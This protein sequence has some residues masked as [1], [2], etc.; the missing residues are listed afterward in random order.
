[1]KT[2][3]LALLITPSF[4]TFSQQTYVPDDNFEAF[5]EGSGLGN[6][7]PN[8]DSVTTSNVSG[9]AD[10][11][12]GSLGIAVIT[13]IEDFTSVTLVIFDGNPITSADFS[14]NDSLEYV[15]MSNCALTSINVSQNVLL[16]TLLCS[17]NSLAS[18]DVSA[19]PL[20]E[21]LNCDGNSLNALDVTQ[22]PELVQLSLNINQVGSIDVTQNT[23]LTELNCV[24]AGLTLLD[25]T[26]NT[27]LISLDCRSNSLTDLDVSQNVALE[28]FFCRANS[29]TSLDVS[30]NPN[31]NNFNCSVNDLY[32]LNADNSNDF[33]N[34][35]APGTYL[36]VSFGNSN[37]TC[38]E[39]SFPTVANSSYIADVGTTFNADC[40]PPMP[41]SSV[42][43]SGTLLTAD[44][45]SAMYQW[46][47][48]DNNNDPIPGA[49]SQ[50]FTPTTTGSYAVEITIA[51]AC[52]ITNTNTSDCFLVDYTGIEELLNTEKELVKIIDLTGRETAFTTNTPLIFMYSD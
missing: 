4:C 11:I 35:L 26:Q 1:M 33:E 45:G 39:V 14:Q 40:L 52:G 43:Q 19:C 15:G 51:N 10:L 38:A 44:L 9:L 3:L 6:G 34:P 27:L 13:G 42:T 46:V 12:V 18:I 17:N 20:L 50:S 22:N 21:V 36:F 30:A 16:K 8:D 49:T 24:Q 28:T 47:D 41:D 29:L 48:C 25:V 2:L 31:L 32:C 5:L 7:I 37:L 23:A